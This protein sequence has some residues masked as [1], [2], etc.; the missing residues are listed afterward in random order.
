MG[1]I[2]AALAVEEQAFR[3]G[4][5]VL[6]KDHKETITGLMNAVRAIE[7]DPGITPEEKRQLID[8]MYIRITE[9]AED[10]LR[11]FKLMEDILKEREDKA[12]SI[13]K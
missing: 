6:L 3:E 5:I 11:Q 9:T 1:E 13:S 7:R 12:R 2:E 10:G 4:K 8:Q